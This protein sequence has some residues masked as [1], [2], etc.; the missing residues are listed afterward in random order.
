MWKGFT[1]WNYKQEEVW[2][3]GQIRMCAV[4]IKSE[5]VPGEIVDDEYK[6]NLPE[7]E[8]VDYVIFRANE[9]KYFAQNVFGT[10]CNNFEALYDLLKPGGKCSFFLS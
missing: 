2:A 1:G 5:I 7:K 4:G 8:S 6:Y 10:E 3:L 9:I